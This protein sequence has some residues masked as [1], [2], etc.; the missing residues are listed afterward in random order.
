MLWFSVNIIKNLYKQLI[1][2]IPTMTQ[3][4]IQNE[5]IQYQK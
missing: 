3:I 1:D 2:F 4:V 5:H